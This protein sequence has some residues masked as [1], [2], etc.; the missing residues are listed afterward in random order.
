VL[1]PGTT[2]GVTQESSSL[3]VGAVPSDQ[4]LAEIEAQIDTAKAQFSAAISD[5]SRTAA[6]TTQIV[7]LY[8]RR[9]TLRGDTVAPR[10]ADAPKM[11]PALAAKRRSLLAKMKDFDM[12]NSADADRWANLKQAELTQ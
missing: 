9:A 11:S 8:Q 4:A 3:T 2:A 10:V 6:L 7:D 5:V 1:D 12:T